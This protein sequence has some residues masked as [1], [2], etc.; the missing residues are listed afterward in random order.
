MGLN[1]AFERNRVN[2]CL[3]PRLCENS[4]PDII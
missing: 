2:F 4:L 1:F 3:W